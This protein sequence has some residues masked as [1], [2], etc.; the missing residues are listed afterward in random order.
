MIDLSY[1]RGDQINITAI[2]DNV[3]AANSATFGY[4]AANRL[5]SAAGPWGSQGWTYEGVGNRTS[6]TATP[7]GGS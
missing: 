6:E 7:P 4:L 1:A 2:T 3:T 5:N